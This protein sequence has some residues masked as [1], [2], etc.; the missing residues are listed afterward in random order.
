MES[1]QKILMLKEKE[2]QK[3]RDDLRRADIALRTE[4]IKMEDFAEEIE[5]KYKDD[6]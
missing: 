3:L 2:N 6:F 5:A 1:L 4:F